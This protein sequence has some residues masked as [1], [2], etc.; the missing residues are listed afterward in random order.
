MKNIIMVFLGLFLNLNAFSQNPNTWVQK[1]SF[2][3]TGREEIIVFV[4]GTKGYAGMGAKYS[5]TSSLPTLYN[6]L[7][8]FDPVLNIWTQKANFSGS[9][10]YGAFGFGTSTKGYVGGGGATISGVATYYNDLWEYNP[11]SNSWIQKANFPG[12]G[13][14]NAFS[15]SI[16]DKGYIGG[17]ATFAPSNYVLFNDF[18]EYNSTANS[19]AQKTTFPGLPRYSMASF[20]INNKIYA[21]LGLSIGTS[22]GAYGPVGSDMYQ[23]DPTTN[24]WLAIAN[25]PDAR[26]DN[27]GFT[28]NG[29][30]YIGLGTNSISFASQKKFYEYNPL[31]NNWRERA[32][33]SYYKEG[34]K[35]FTLNGGGYYLGGYTLGNPNIVYNDNYQYIPCSNMT[36]GTIYDTICSNTNY[37][38]NGMQLNSSGTYFDTLY[39][40]IGCDSILTL[41]LTVLPAPSATISSNNITQICNPGGSLNISSNTLNTTQYIWYKN[42]VLITGAS[43][44]S[45]TATAAGSYFLKVINTK[46][47]CYTNSNSITLTAIAAPPSTITPTT[48]PLTLCEGSYIAATPSVGYTYQ[49]FQYNNPIAGQ[50]AYNFMCTQNG[51]YNC[52]ITAPN[53]CTTTS[54]NKVVTV[55]PKPIITITNTGLDTLCG[56][57]FDI[58][59]TTLNSGITPSTYLWKVNSINSGQP[60][61]LNSYNTNLSPLISGANNTFSVIITD[62]NGCKDTSNT[63]TIFKSSLPIPTIS[64]NGYVLSSNLSSTINKWYL[65]NIL[66]TGQNASVLTPTQDGQYTFSYFQDNCDVMSYPYLLQNLGILFKKIDNSSFIVYPNPAKNKITITPFIN[67]VYLIVDLYGKEVINSIT[68]N[69]DITSLSE[70]IYYLLIKNF[71][72]EIIGTNKLIKYN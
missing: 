40:S 68:N 23:Y 19:W 25:F 54:V 50:T 72:G 27:S 10:R 71:E 13:R 69:I 18:W 65:N 42:N 7:W 51:I 9:N 46:S 3:I 62:V 63:I 28:I 26:G 12:V 66:I 21:G 20:V 34:Q 70:G 17:G 14:L 24:N 57:N 15:E 31:V 30:G 22:G 11:T 41:N 36:Y 55:N 6:D 52:L 47:T 58:I 48:N 43:S 35:S 1:S 2:L 37:S 53:G 67:G 4:I 38:F 39:N 44:N 8:E 29:K 45:Y 64:F 5:N 33:F 56:N 16:N 59:T 60:S 61:G 32:T 49:W